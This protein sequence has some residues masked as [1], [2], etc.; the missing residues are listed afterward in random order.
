MKCTATVEGTRA[1]A[2][3]GARSSAR[4]A[5]STAGQ[6]ARSGN[7]PMTSTLGTSASLVP[8]WAQTPCTAAAVA[9]M[10]TM[11]LK[12][13]RGLAVGFIVISWAAVR[14]R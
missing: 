9:T 13:W 5:V 10:A 7:W 8:A 14:G 6:A 1:S 12:G 4:S 3:A 2:Q 11:A